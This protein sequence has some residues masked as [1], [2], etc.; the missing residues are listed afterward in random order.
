MS[1]F[2]PL[3]SA[4]RSLAAFALTAASCGAMAM[5]QPPETPAPTD[6]A[7]KV[8]ITFTADD[9]PA[10]LA[11]RR[12]LE[13]IEIWP[14]KDQT[15][16]SHYRVYWG[17]AGKNKL[18]L[19]LA[20]VQA[21]I[22]ANSGQ[23]KLV[24]EFP[25][26][27][28]MEAGA[29][30]VLVCSVN[31]DA[32]GS[33]EYCPK[34]NNLE[35]ISDPLLTIAGN[36][37]SIKGL[38]DTELNLPGVDVMATCGDLVCNGVETI[39]SCPSDCSDYK[40]ASFNFQTLCHDVEEVIHPT[41]VE[42]IQQ[43]VAR[44]N[45]EKKRIKMT[46]GRGYNTTSGSA[47]TI[48][49]NDGIVLV[50]DKF[51]QQQ[52]ALGM[53]LETF[54]GLDVVNVAAGAS[55]HEVGE[56]LFERNKGLGYVHLGWRDVSVA[57]AL[58]TSAHGSSPKNRNV[59]SQ[60]VVSIDLI[61][62][63]GALKTYSRG[64]TGKT[65]PDLWKS[66]TTHLGYLGVLTRVRLEVSE[67]TNTHVKITFHDEDEL[68]TAAT[69][70]VLNDIKD[71]DY[72]QYNWFPS[73]NRYLRTC[74]TT[75]DAA[76]EEGAN[77]ELLFPYV[78]TDQLSTKDTMQIFQIGGAKPDT[79]AH[80]KM[81]YM[82]K[83]GWHLTPP[84]TKTIN[85]E[86]RYTS[87]AVGPTHRITSSKLIDTIGREM[88]QMDWEF[89]VPQ[90]N[91]QAAMEYIREFNNGLNT[92]NREIPVPL[93]GIFVRFSKVGDQ[94]LMAYT[95]AGNG[96]EN[97]TTAVHI[98]MPIFVPVNLTAEQFAEYMDP[99]EEAMRKLITDFGARGHWGKNMYAEQYG[100]QDWVFTLQRDLKVYGDHLE[101]FNKQIGKLDPN[102]LFANKF[103]KA[104]G[105][106]YPNFEYPASW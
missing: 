15:N 46:S 16:L 9:N 42:Q 55:L 30:Y 25:A 14:A 105:I 52:Q 82:R 22:A 43:I 10:K 33:K 94:A 28:R 96:F 80:E 56:W 51:N 92:K 90:K 99:Y 87:N 8:R 63:S 81:A 83:A 6:V 71:C 19:G 5:S 75:T 73:L 64:T 36:L 40:L 78:D 104:I 89:A 35:Q 68:F 20:P 48:V 79:Q 1:Y 4:A 2:S 67:A 97:G 69:D 98:E 76:A 50:M 103:G 24:Y 49:C 72:G 61:D 38:L 77:N 45:K 60:Q 53:S 41:S 13:G 54:E 86:K 23:Q 93:I 70:S 12:I 74:G 11:P 3:T 17:D 102:G 66:L 85:G 95:G 47:T 31:K 7:E 91:I 29:M 39:T 84:L 106:E 59:L 57:G 18:G 32:N 21:E 62:A 88:F 44:A 27:F 34:E 100:N 37:S 101:R 65:D 26:N 58:G